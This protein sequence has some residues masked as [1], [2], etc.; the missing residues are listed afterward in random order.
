M[1]KRELEQ[2]VVSLDEVFG[3][4]IMGVLSVGVLNGAL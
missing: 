1:V 4:F 2:F 3:V